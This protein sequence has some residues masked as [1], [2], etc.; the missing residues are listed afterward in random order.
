MPALINLLVPVGN[1]LGWSTAPALASGWG[2]LDTD[3]T[4]Q[5]IRAASANPRTRW[6]CTVI[7]PDGSAIAHGCA[8][9]QHRWT[10]ATQESQS[11]PGGTRDGPTPRQATQLGDLLRRLNATLHPIAKGDCDHAHA[12]NG[13]TPSRTLKHLIRART[14]TCPAPGCN[15]QSCN[16]DID[17]TIAYPTGAT[18]ECNLSP[19]CRR[20]HRV[21]QARGWRLEQPEPGVMR[22]TTP[23]GR[24]Y[25]STPTVYD[26]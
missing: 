18:D 5:I 13:Y 16:N 9:G 11:D 21:K 22:W 20:H 19:P 14:A 15:A 8:R 3:E 2:L 23:A 17:H 25:I 6:C 1:L 7:G 26:L 24:I 12:E 10:Q 4:R